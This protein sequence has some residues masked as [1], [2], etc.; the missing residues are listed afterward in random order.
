MVLIAAAGITLVV[1]RDREARQVTERNASS[2]ATGPNQIAGQDQQRK[3]QSYL[4]RV[5]SASPAS[6][7]PMKQPT[8]STGAKASETI[9]A[10]NTQPAAPK[11]GV[12]A[13]AEP[14][15]TLSAATQPSKTDL[16]PSFA[17]PPPTENE[18][19]Q[20]RARDTQSVGGTGARKGEVA[21]A[22]FGALDR[23]QSNTVQRS[24]SNVQGLSNNNA[25]AQT[26]RQ[27]QDAPSTANIQAERRAGADKLLAK[28]KESDDST[29]AGRTSD[30]RTAR[31]AGE[32]AKR[33]PAPAVNEEK[34]ETRSLNGRK[35]R[36]QGTA[37]IDTKFKSSM[38]VKGVSRG[39]DEYRALDAGLRSIVE[40][41][42][43]DALIVWKGKAYRIH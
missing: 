26:Q 33:T 25:Q 29:R 15:P 16:S 18:R 17:P 27:V 32:S 34:L 36:K 24:Q 10:Q 5:A 3:S 13:G 9:V 8:P 39:S 1:L 37:W 42:G 22:N 21:N 38:S 35:F 11:P 12:V 30:V 43:G 28:E 40:Q 19:A 2:A 7:E 4:D 41:L 23:M 6:R 20:N 14:Q 31:S